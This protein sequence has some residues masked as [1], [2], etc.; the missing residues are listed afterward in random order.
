MTTVASGLA[1]TRI[2]LSNGAIVLVKETRKTPAVTLNVAMRAGSVC[3]PAGSPGAMYLLSRVIDRGTV[4]RSAAAIA[5]ELDNR[6]VSLNIV[7]S[8]HLFSLLCTCLAE[9]VE[10]ILELLGDI[11]TA[12]TVPDA[13]LATRKGEVI[14]LLRQDEDNPAVRAVEELMALLYGRSHEYGRPQKGTSDTVEH[15]TREQ[16]L[17]LHAARFAPA[18]LTVVVVG[19]VDSGRVAAITDQVFGSWRAAS[20]VPVHL[21]PP[22]LATSRRRRVIPMMNK[23]QADIAYGFTTITRRDPA[24]YAYWLMNNALGQYA[25]GGRLG[26]SIRERQGMAYYVSSAFDPNIVEGPLMIRAGVSAPNVDRAIASIDEELSAVRRSG[27]TAKELTESRQY[28]IGSLPRSLET[29]AAIAQFLQSAEF[30]GLGLD[31]DV[32]LPDLLGRVT[33]DEVHAAAQP[34]DPERATVV[35]AGPYQG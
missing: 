18:A 16:L 24:Y 23:S 3:D 20:P 35:V 17:E 27:I 29:N 30:F 4:T 31:Y 32:R 8:R 19:D 7:V 2:V 33:I 14:T 1:P 26:D 21:S 28:L 34:L 6:G 12:P 22:P 15:L 5:D 25:L 13:E 11:V 10:P 9:D